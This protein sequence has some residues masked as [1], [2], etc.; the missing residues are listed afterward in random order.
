M[1]RRL[2]VAGFLVVAASVAAAGPI[3]EKAIEAERLLDA[4]RPLEAAQALDAAVEAAWQEMPLTVRNIQQV[5]EATGYGVYVPRESHV[6]KPG[7][8]LFVYAELLGYQLGQDPIGNKLI[9]TDLGIKLKNETGKTLVNID[10]GFSF[11]QAVRVFNK[12]F[13]FKVD[14]NFKGA[15]PG[16]YIAELTVTDRASSKSTT[17]EIP[18]EIAL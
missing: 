11:A 4:G 17:F 16:K 15:P 12:E 8:K 10:K 7:E 3:A 18:F 1:L 6:Y 14:L 2:V 9:A 13:F 5:T